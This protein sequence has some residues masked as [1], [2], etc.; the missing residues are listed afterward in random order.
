MTE[1]TLR[2]P[3]DL[4]N[5]VKKAAQSVGMTT[6]QFFLAIINDKFTTYE[7]FNLYTDEPI[8]QWV[9]TDK[10]SD[11]PVLFQLLQKLEPTNNSVSMKWGSCLQT[12]CSLEVE[13]PPDWS[14]HIDDYLYGEKCGK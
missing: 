4:L 2:I 3:D 10:F 1:Y 6:N 8:A 9:A 7:Q 5:K 14:E 11:K 13:G 12:A